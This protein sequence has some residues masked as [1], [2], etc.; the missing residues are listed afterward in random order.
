MQTKKKNGTISLV[1]V[2]P[3]TVAH[4]HHTNF[5]S[6]LHHSDVRLELS[7]RHMQ[8]HVSSNSINSLSLSSPRNRLSSTPSVYSLII[9]IC[10]YFFNIFFSRS[11]GQWY[12]AI[13]Q[14]WLR[15]CESLTFFSR[16]PRYR[17]TTTQYN[18]SCLFFT[19]SPSFFVPKKCE[20]LFL[21]FVQWSFFSILSPFHLFKQFVTFTA[22]FMIY[23][24][25]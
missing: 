16:S 19:L 2:S 4:N 20:P 9:N 22:P 8:R 1:I 12:G 6:D 13:R 15:K 11:F 5:I 7:C 14:A 24:S 17:I 3:P 21:Y 18:C 10:W 25:I 23:E